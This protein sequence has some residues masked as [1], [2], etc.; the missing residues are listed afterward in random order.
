LAEIYRELEALKLMTRKTAWMQDIRYQE[1]G[2][3]E[4][5]A[6][7]MTF[8]P[9][10]IAKWISLIKWKGPSLALDAA[11]KAMLWFGAAGYTKDYLLEAAWRGVMSYV[12]GA[13]G[14]QNIQKLVVARELLGKEYLP[15]R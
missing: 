2:L 3:P 11:K 8:K 13:E 15:Y 1:E 5:I 10:E 6:K 7:A 9:K 14:G 12:I 4:R